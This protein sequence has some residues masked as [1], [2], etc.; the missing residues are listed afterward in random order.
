MDRETFLGGSVA[1]VIIRLVLLSVVVGVILSALGITPDNIFERINV[2]LQRIYDLGFGAL[3]SLLGYF[4][5]GA[6][7]VVPIWFISRLLKTA[8]KS[9]GTPRDG[10]QA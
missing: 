10:G 9:D 5:L 4:I 3:D 2:L 6:I 1:G 7:V 8:G